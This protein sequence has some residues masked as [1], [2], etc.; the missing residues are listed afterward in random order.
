MTEKKGWFLLQWT[1]DGIQ[2]FNLNQVDMSSSQ[3]FDEDA[4]AQ[5]SHRENILDAV[6]DHKTN[7]MMEHPQKKIIHFPRKTLSFCHIFP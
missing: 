2:W 3:G 1:H 6:S 5:I 7:V 4:A